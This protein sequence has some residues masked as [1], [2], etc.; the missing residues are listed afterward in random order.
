MRLV[1]ST[2]LSCTA[3]LL[4]AGCAAGYKAPQMP[5][6]EI[7]TLRGRNATFIQSVDQQPVHSVHMAVLGM[8]GGNDVQ[9]TPG[10]HDI[11]VAVDMGGGQRTQLL[12]L[13]L[14]KGHTY[15]FAQVYAS[16]SRLQIT[17]VTDNRKWWYDWRADAFLPDAEP[18]QPTKG[19][20]SP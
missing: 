9:V 6:E 5:A 4:L 10:R 15:E 20:I 11:W 13:E 7:V 8:V 12:R 19:P 17:N 18:A 14:Q 16:T 3:P 2:L 1:Y